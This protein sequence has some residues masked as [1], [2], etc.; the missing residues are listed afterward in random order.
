MSLEKDKAFEG[1]LKVCQSVD[2][3]VGEWLIDNAGEDEDYLRPFKEIHSDLSKAINK[4]E[5]FLQNSQKNL[6]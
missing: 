2:E 5:K 1:L 6:K 4:A 3:F